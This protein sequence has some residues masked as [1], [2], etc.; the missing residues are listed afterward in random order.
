M[1]TNVKLKYIFQIIHIK[2]NQNFFY[3]SH[4]YHFILEGDVSQGLSCLVG[5]LNYRITGLS[6]NISFVEIIILP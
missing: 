4:I 1:F 3:C 6:L 5:S 2:R